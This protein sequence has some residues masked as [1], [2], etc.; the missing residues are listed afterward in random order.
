[1]GSQKLE[2]QLNLALDTPEDIRAQTGNLNVGY[3]PESNMWEL[4]VR[5]EG[6][7]DRVRALGALVTPLINNYGIVVA[8]QNI[9][10]TIARLE[11]IIYVEKPKRLNFAIENGKRVSCINRV[12]EAPFNL[13]G[14]GCIVCIIDSGIDYAHSAFLTEDGES[15]ILELWDQSLS[16]VDY[17]PPT[18]Y[19]IGALF[20]REDI[21][22]ALKAPLSERFNIVNS[23]DIS[24]HGTSVAGIAANIAWGADLIIVKLDNPSQIGFP[25][26]TQLMQAIDFCVNRGVRYGRPIAINISFGNNYG[27]HDG[28]SLLSTF[29]DSASN[30]GRNII[31]IGTGNEGAMSAHTSGRI[32][33]NS[34]RQ[35]QFNIGRF[36]KNVNIQIWKTYG[37]SLDF[38][39]I[40]FNDERL[41]IDGYYRG[42]IDRILG[43]NRVLVYVGEPSPYSMYQEI[44][45]EIIPLNEYIDEGQWNINVI[46]KR[47]IDGRF[48]LWLGGNNISINTR[49]LSP[50]ADTT[51][52]IPSA[53]NRAISV[54][55]YDSLDFSYADF[56]GRGFTRNTNQ[57][58]PDIVAPGVNI[59]TSIP[60]GGMA[61]RTGTS[62]ATPFVTG[63]GAL[64]M[65]W[66]IING[67]DL[68]MYGE[69]VK[70]YLIKGARR[71]R[72]VDVWPDPRFGWGALCV[73]DSISIN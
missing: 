65:E 13:T 14:K 27:S 36:E 41:F 62:F 9:I 11:E 46:A 73:E 49:F 12:Q 35:I 42:S 56:S 8:P 21:N 44:Y 51:L 69:K 22:R 70:A 72:G 71:F 10:D 47:V 29:I 34:S 32:S 48:D 59:L 16:D 61:E 4:I 19:N 18:G 23:K 26:T 24:G 67:N 52:T 68:Y 5:Y 30:I 63:A 60:G 20:T 31:V 3:L 37:D 66:G 1:M 28:T 40:S 53:S 45:I 6:S 43:Q 39:L 33:E 64:L 2:N 58:K 55:A 25:S 50:V 38:E 57:V 7:L 17:P 54:G 15:R